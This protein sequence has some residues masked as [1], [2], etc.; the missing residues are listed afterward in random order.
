MNRYKSVSREDGRGRVGV[1]MTSIARGANVDAR[2]IGICE[3]SRWYSEILIFTIFTIKRLS[4]KN[5][6]FIILYPE[7]SIWKNITVTISCPEKEYFSIICVLH[8]KLR[9]LSQTSNK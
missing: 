6:A 7:I 4:R 9:Y 3:K 8:F 1:V 2:R 5:N